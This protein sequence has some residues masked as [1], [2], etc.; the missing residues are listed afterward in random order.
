MKKHQGN[1][2][3]VLGLT[4]AVVLLP[5]ISQAKEATIFDE[6][7][8][9]FYYK[10]LQ[11]QIPFYEGLLGLKKTMDEDWVKIYQ[12]SATSSVGIVLQGRGFHDVAND[13]PAMLSIV[14]NDIEMWYQRLQAAAVPI[15]SELAPSDTDPEVGQAPVRSFIVEDPGGYT[16]EFFTWRNTD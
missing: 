15:L 6:T 12:I 9:F 11:A 8:T 3:K 14:T 7:I 2:F 16:V 10:D 4:M 13:K 1:Y 5:V